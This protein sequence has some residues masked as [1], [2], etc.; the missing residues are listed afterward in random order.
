MSKRYDADV[1][2]AGGGVVG[3]AM[4]AYLGKQ[5]KKVIVVEKTLKEQD[6]IVGEL[7]QP[8]GVIEL[9]RMGLE[10]AL[11]GFDAAPVTG[12]ALYHQNEH[13]Q[14]DYPLDP[15]FKPMAGRGFH[16]GKFILALRKEFENLDNVQIIEG[17]VREVLTHESTGEVYGLGYTPKG[18]KESVQLF[19][20]LTVV[21]DG[22]FSMFR[23]QFHMEE[24]FV[25]G[26]F[27]GLVLKNADLPYDKCGHVVIADPSPFLCYPIS[28]T[29]TR[30]LIDYPG[31]EPPKRGPHL[32]KYLHE[33]ILPQM[34]ESLKPSFKEAIES[35]AVK[36]M[37][38]Q[39]LPCRPELKR[40]AVLVGDS[41]NMRHPLTGGG[42]TVALT[43][44]RILGEALCNM[45]DFHDKQEL[46]EVV[47]MFYQKRQKPNATINIL[48][49][50]LY[51]V[52][53]NEDLKHACFEYLQAGGNQASEPIAML[54]GLNRDR[55]LLLRHFF[56]V[57]FHGMRKLLARPTTER[58]RRA[59]R[60]LNDAV[61][62]IDPLLMHNAPDLTTKSALA[63]GRLLFPFELDGVPKQKSA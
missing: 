10:S 15:Y 54:S 45:R 46:D 22:C 49:D 28:S 59:Y 2:I 43:D 42:M 62:I 38:N 34:P 35:Q 21:S 6:R 58:V 20:P 29:E 14:V 56:A 31:A 41:L 24:P 7:L 9:H 39:H 61:R 50:A 40:G 57:A 4:A 52:M 25:R 3:A 1:L 48:A 53:L 27:M 51:G 18:S 36:V 44:V 26:W 12:Y 30:V 17:A 16:N 32:Q 23:K 55:E 13:F 37:P 11:E 5:G 8:G 60:M 33:V 19:A 47:E 63:V